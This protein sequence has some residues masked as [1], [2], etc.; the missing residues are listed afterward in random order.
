MSSESRLSNL[1]TSIINTG[2]APDEGESLNDYV[3][4]FPKEF[5]KTYDNI[6][7]DSDGFMFINQDRFH[8]SFAQDVDPT[9]ADIM[10]IVQKPVNQSIF[11][12]KSG[13]PARKQLPTWYQVS[14]NDRMIYPDTERL[15]AERMDAYTISLN[16]SHASLV[17]H[18]DEIAELILNATKG[19]TLAIEMI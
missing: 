15:S 18:P 3:A 8:E 9:E 2:W 1:F 13:P 10:A 6:K 5:L 14:E 12:E 7:P 11:G 19:R 16:S 17:S 4:K